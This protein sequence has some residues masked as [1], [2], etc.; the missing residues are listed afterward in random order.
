M[1]DPPNVRTPTG[2]LSHRRS[3]RVILFAMHATSHP[4]A[5][6]RPRAHAPYEHARERA[7]EALRTRREAFDDA[8]RQPDTDPIDLIDDAQALEAAEALVEMLEQGTAARR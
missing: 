8:Q 5:H 1:V 7:I 3:T 6:P 4:R 2:C